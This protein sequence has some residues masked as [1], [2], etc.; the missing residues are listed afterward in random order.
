MNAVE[1]FQ[2]W[3][4]QY[5]NFEHNPKKGIFWLDTI[6]FL[7]DRFQNPEQAFNSVHIAGSKGKGSVSRM[8]SS[9]LDKNG[10]NTGVYSSPHITDFRER[11]ET[12]EGFFPEEIYEKAIREMVPRIESILPEQLPG[13]RPLTWFELVTLFGF[14]C[15]RQAKIDWGVF[16]VGMGGRL[17]STNII[18]PKICCINVIELE[19]TEYLGDTIEKI[20]YEKA[21]I[22]KEGVPVLIGHQKYEAANE[23]FKKVAAEKKAPVYFVDD[24]IDEMNY[25][26]TEMGLMEVNISSKY[27]SRQIHTFMPMLGSMQLQNAALAAM[28]IRFILPEV[29]V[30]TIERGLSNSMLPGRFEILH[31]VRNF[32]ELETLILDGAHTVNS[33]NLTINTLKE[34]RDLGNTLIVVEHDEDTMKACD[35]LVDIGPKAG[36]HGGE[37]VALGTPIE[38]M[39]NPN[40][41]TGLYLS[42]KLKIE[43]PKERRK[44]DGRF[45]EVV[46]AK[47][48]N[49]KNVNVKFPLGVITVVTGVSGSGKSSLVNEVLYKNAYIKLYKSKKIL[50]AKTASSVSELNNIEVDSVQLSESDYLKDFESVNVVFD[51]KEEN[52]FKDVVFNKDVHYCPLKIF[53]ISNNYKL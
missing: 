44:L 40:S 25:R 47:Q 3:L 5:L 33:V 34:M 2:D 21:G 20:A 18:T 42:G 31:S 38:V 50:E 6:K 9:I 49:L 23:V 43:V 41:I 48:N 46:G 30:K 1:V 22:I 51:E 27:F 45:L 28:A 4:D 19:H 29:D 37:V 14:L 13:E 26:Y 11:I 32:P 53:S 12:P 36:V 10:F 24:M 17:D 15:F 52:P 7:C 39:N 35:F 16:E 8:I